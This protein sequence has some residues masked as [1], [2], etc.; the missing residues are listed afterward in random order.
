MSPF[1][2]KLH[3]YLQG[4]WRAFKGWKQIKLAGELGN[5]ASCEKPIRPLDYYL[6]DWDRRV[7]HERCAKWRL[8][9]A[10]EWV[11]Q[12]RDLEPPRMGTQPK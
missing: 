12:A 11:L 4:F 1:L 8:K 2:R 5:C 10:F 3:A 7:W 9:K 6:Y